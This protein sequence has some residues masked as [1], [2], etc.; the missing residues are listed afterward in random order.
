[1]YGTI[2]IAASLS[3][4][5]MRDDWLAAFMMS[6]ILL[7][8]QLLLYSAALGAARCLRCA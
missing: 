5:G 2:P 4:S 1:M 7:N 6:S 3:R 8:P